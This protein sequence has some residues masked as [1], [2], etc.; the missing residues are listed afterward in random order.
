MT[1][2]AAVVTFPAE[3]PAKRPNKPRNRDFVAAYRTWLRTPSNLRAEVRPTP[4]TDG[5]CAK[6]VKHV[7]Y[8]RYRRPLELTDI[9]ARRGERLGSILTE[10]AQ[11]GLAATC[12]FEDTILCRPL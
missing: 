2:T 4:Q 9:W 7:T 5:N 6:H 10:R 11:S 3:D 8:A 1:T 12:W